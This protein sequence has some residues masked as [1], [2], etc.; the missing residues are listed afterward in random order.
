MIDGNLAMNSHF[1]NMSETDANEMADHYIHQKMKQQTPI[2]ILQDYGGT[3]HDP[4]YSISIDTSDASKA[5]E[6]YAQ[7]KSIL[8]A[9]WIAKRDWFKDRDGSWQYKSFEMFVKVADNTEQL[10][11]LFLKDSKQINI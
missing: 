5:I 7:I 11:Q 2:Q 8:F 9:E 10:Y 1:E 6:E 3:I 4:S